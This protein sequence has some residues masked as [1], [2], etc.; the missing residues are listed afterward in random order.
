MH[1]WVVQS[2]KVRIEMAI[3]RHF[4]SEIL[5][6]DAGSVT[7]GMIANLA[8]NDAKIAAN[9]AIAGSKL[10]DGGITNAKIAANAAIA[11][12]KLA[13][14]AVDTAQIADGAVANAQVDAA[15]GIVG[16]KLAPEVRICTI[17]SDVISLT[18]AAPATVSKVLMM[19]STAITITKARLIYEVASDAGSVPNIQVGI[20]GDLA[21]IVAAEAAEINKAAFAF[22]NLV[23]LVAAVAADKALVF[24]VVAG[25]QTTNT[26]AVRL[27][28]EY[29]VDD[30][31]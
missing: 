12:T 11:G 19:P 10:A 4:G 22:K 17:V 6:G 7:Q 23:Q 15:A 9:A 14:K 26:G 18:N 16:S 21:S 2:L 20:D 25:A 1:P 30:A 31:V 27:A 3:P 28:V 29:T 24:S 13:N 5:T 8:I